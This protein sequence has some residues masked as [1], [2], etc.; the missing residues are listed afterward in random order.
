MS[1]NGVIFRLVGHCMHSL[2]GF[3]FFF[4]FELQKNKKLWPEVLA[5]VTKN[6]NWRLH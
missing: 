3:I 1:T 2:V 4:F 6:T 5:E